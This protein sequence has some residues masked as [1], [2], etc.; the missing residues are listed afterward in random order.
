MHFCHL[1][2]VHD[3]KISTISRGVQRNIHPIRSIGARAS[4]GPGKGHC[5]VYIFFFKNHEKNWKE[6]N[7]RGKEK[8]STLKSSNVIISRGP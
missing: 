5:I 2:Y 6:K 4:G 3:F 7:K 1:D 8:L